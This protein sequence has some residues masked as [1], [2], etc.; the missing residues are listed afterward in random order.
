MIKADGGLGTARLH[1]SEPGSNS[2]VCWAPDP[3]L[4]VLGWR[5]GGT[6]P[7][8]QAEGNAQAEGHSQLPG[9][10]DDRTEGTHGDVILWKRVGPVFA[11]QSSCGQRA[12]AGRRV[13]V[14]HVAVGAVWNW[15]ATALGFLPGPPWSTCHPVPTFH[16]VLDHCSAL[17]GAYTSQKRPWMQTHPPSPSYPAIF[18]G[19][20]SIFPPPASW[21]E[22]PASVNF[23]HLSQHHA[24]RLSNGLLA[25]VGGRRLLS[26]AQPA[27]ESPGDLYVL[28]FLS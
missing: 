3:V 9:T 17:E 7:A 26:S 20:V 19:L 6:H 4:P 18:P 8:F 12:R 24:H 25:G 23:P 13:T 15:K 27:P 14:S 16:G 28:W 21:A 10:S 22:A 1:V 5:E 11:G 2:R